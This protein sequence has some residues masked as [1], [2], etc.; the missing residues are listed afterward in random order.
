MLTRLGK[1]EKAFD[2][3]FGVVVLPVPYHL[4]LQLELAQAPIRTKLFTGEGLLSRRLD[5]WLEN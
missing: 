5:S 2:N 1:V 4:E 3:V